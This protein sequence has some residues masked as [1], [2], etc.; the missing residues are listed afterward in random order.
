M[1]YDTYYFTLIEIDIIDY[2][3]NIYRMAYKVITPD[4]AT[5]SRRAIYFLLHLYITPNTHDSHAFSPAKRKDDIYAFNA[6]THQSLPARR[7]R[8]VRF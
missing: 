7:Q 4:A 8:S 3:R 5:A 6:F 1:R 2:F